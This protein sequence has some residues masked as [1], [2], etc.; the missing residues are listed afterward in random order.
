MG[1][2]MYGYGVRY[3]GYLDDW[4]VVLK[5]GANELPRGA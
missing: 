1:G 5:A 2:G 3:E 4:K